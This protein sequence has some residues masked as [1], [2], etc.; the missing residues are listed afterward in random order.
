M[1]S[2]REVL[3][4]LALIASSA[5]LPLDA[6]RALGSGHPRRLKTIGL[7]LYTVRDAM[8]KDFKGTLERVASIGFKEVEFAGYYD[9]P[10]RDIRRLLDSLGLDAPAAH[11]SV[12]DLEERWAVMIE[13]AHDLG[14]RYLVV[15]SLPLDADATQ[16]DYKRAASTLTRL[17]E[18]CSK[19]G[20]TLGFHNHDSE[21]RAIDGVLPYDILLKESDPKVVTMELDLYW[22][23]KAGA[24][25]IRYFQEHPGRFS[26]FHVKDMA[27]G[28][29]G[30]TT[31]VGDG[32]IDFGRLFAAS[33]PGVKH[34]FV[35]QEEFTIDPLLS[36][37]KSWKYLHSLEF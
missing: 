7:Q 31:E 24:D 15:A 8:K 4:T 34:F 22:I 37:E 2:R 1:T 3:R 12:K 9:N 11:C 26:L 28:S 21:F 23:V 35:E 17:G 25:P 18:Q 13:S 32:S 29:E 33:H 6:R 10:P 19:E 36:V 14:H 5:M 30:G 27:A 16:D 20:L